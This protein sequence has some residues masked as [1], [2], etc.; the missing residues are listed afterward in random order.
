MIFD[1]Q[2]DKRREELLQWFGMRN[3]DGQER[4]WEFA[5]LL[6]QDGKYRRGVISFTDAVRRSKGG[7]QA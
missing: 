4:V 7:T 6:T 3:A 1:T 2:E 5:G